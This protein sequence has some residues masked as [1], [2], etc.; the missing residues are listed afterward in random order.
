MYMDFI[1][2]TIKE[3]ILFMKKFVNNPRRI[4]S[5]A[6]SSS[7]LTESILANVEWSSVGSV[8][9]LGAGTGVFTKNII[10]RMGNNSNI[11]IF[12]IEPE[13]RSRLETQT[14]LKIYSDAV[15]LPQ[16]LESRG[17][18]HV[19]LII[20]SLPYAVLPKEETDSILKSI[21]KSLGPEGVF[22][23]FQYSLHMREPFE[24]IFSSVRTRFVPLN[25]PPA[26]VYEC[27]GLLKQQYD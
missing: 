9:E 5:I 7:F 18:L 24:K 1:D 12:E 14:K 26:F 19:D 23:A 16:I 2:E 6:P 10:Q 4:G 27:T 22:L 13:L 21:I 17:I 11:F 25:I 15:K 8:A 20:S 3:K